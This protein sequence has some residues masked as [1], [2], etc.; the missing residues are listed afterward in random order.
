MWSF[1][2]PKSGISC[3]M[4]KESKKPRKQNG[5]N[6]ISSYRR[7]DRGEGNTHVDETSAT[8]RLF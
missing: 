1:A 8:G 5:G 6:L 4:N 3:N 2:L 7:N